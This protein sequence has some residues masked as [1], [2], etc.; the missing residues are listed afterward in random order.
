MFFNKLLLHSKFF[1]LS[2]E[3][4][5]CEEQ[6]SIKLTYDHLKKIDGI[7]SKLNNSELNDKIYNEFENIIQNCDTSP[8][9]QEKLLHLSHIILNHF[10]T[11]SMPWILAIYKKVMNISPLE[12][13]QDYHE[14]IQKALN[15]IKSENITENT[16]R[17]FTCVDLVKKAHETDSLHSQ[18]KYAQVLV[19][20]LSHQI[21]Q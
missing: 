13:S 5:R 1:E 6:N 9:N 14:M 18:H 17:R 2:Q 19:R 8:A 10:S 11:K 3:I 7:L 21:H 20:L 15:P 12:T 16:V 4:K